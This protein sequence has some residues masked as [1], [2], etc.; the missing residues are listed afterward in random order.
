MA[1]RACREVEEPV[2]RG[3]LVR[4]EDAV[5]IVD[6]EGIVVMWNLAAERILGYPTRAAVGRPGCEIVVAEATPPSIAGRSPVEDN[7][8]SASLPWPIASAISVHLTPLAFVGGP[9]PPPRTGSASDGHNG[10][11]MRDPSDLW[12]NGEVVTQWGLSAPVLPNRAPAARRRPHSANAL[13]ARLSG[14]PDQTVEWSV[15]NFGLAHALPEGG[16]AA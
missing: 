13:T 5:F 9:V 12:R 8:A 10:A 4:A 11:T 1:E 7:D 16:R 14:S 6:T 15:S 2:L 3:A